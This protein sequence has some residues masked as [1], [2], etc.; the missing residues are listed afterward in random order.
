[1]FDVQ[2]LV[3]R[4]T[5]DAYDAVRDGVSLNIELYFE[6]STLNFENAL[7]EISIRRSTFRLA[8]WHTVDFAIAGFRTDVGVPA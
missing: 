1:M 7:V 3:L 8:I 6:L 2:F 4:K 5:R